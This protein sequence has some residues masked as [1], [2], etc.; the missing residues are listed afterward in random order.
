MLDHRH[1]VALAGEL[2]AGGNAQ[3]PLHEVHAR[4]HLGNG[5]LHLQARVH[6]HEVE[7]AGV[8]VEELNG[9]HAH[10][11]HLAGEVARGLVHGG[12]DVVVALQ[13]GGGALLQQ[14]LVAALHG[15][16]ALAQRHHIARHVGKDL[17]LHVVRGVHELLHVALAVAKGALGLGMGLV[18]GGCGILGTLNF[19]DAASAAARARLDK[20]GAAYALGL[21]RGVI[22]AGK[23]VAAGNHGH[24][25]GAGRPAGGVLVAHARDDLGRGA[26]EHEAVVAALTRKARVL[27]EEAVARVNGLRA[28]LERHRDDG[29]LVEVALLRTRPADAVGLVR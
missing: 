17:H 13:A 16:L 14:L 6:L 10:I 15:A 7:L 12:A 20:H 9:A 5:V 2:L 26:R 28:A 23:Q 19:A 27:G 3:L 25:R 11:A 24:A 4:H 21:S 29:V 22:G 1:L 18:V 8:R